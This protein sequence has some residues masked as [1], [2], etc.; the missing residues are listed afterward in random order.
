VVC[1][2]VMLYSRL[3]H[4]HRI[5]EKKEVA[6][7]E[8]LVLDIFLELPGTQISLPLGSP[9]T[10]AASN[11]ERSDAFLLFHLSSRPIGHIDHFE[12]SGVL[13]HLVNLSRTAHL[14]KIFEVP[15]KKIPSS[16]SARLLY[17]LVIIFNTRLPKL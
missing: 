11:E 10:L 14:L 13:L 6:L 7:L 3:H 2:Q 15:K 17:C 4:S 1:R 5:S 9:P 12:S 8:R 16:L